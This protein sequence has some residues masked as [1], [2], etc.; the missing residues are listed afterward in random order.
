MSHG[1]LDL[2]TG[3]G[4]RPAGRT[5]WVRGAAQARVVLT[6]VANE[7]PGSGMS[8]VVS[9]GPHPAGHVLAAAWAGPDLGSFVITDIP[10]TDMT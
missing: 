3:G 9:V 10:V 5:V 6:T 2:V 1:S 7:A 4:C 8:G